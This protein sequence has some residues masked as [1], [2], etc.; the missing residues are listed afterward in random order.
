MDE[1]R[2]DLCNPKNFQK[3]KDLLRPILSLNSLATSLKTF[4]L[5]VVMKSPF[6][7]I[8]SSLSYSISRYFVAILKLT[9]A[10]HTIRLLFDPFIA[11]LKISTAI[12]V[13]LLF[14][15][16]IPPHVKSKCNLC[17][18]LFEKILKNRVL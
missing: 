6:S 7:C 16:L 4:P 11:N 18:D 8:I 5:S 2:S 3:I 17:K 10:S 12:S 14:L 1:T 9:F 15:I 13:L